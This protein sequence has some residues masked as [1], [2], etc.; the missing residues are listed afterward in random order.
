METC[1]YYIGLSVEALTSILSQA[2]KVL[3][4]GLNS[5]HSLLV[6]LPKNSRNAVFLLFT[7]AKHVPLHYSFLR[8]FNQVSRQLLT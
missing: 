2:A 3:G 8:G 7:V 6:S 5:L 1:N 4:L